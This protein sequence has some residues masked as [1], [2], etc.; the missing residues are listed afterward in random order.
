MSPANPAIEQL[1]IRA[2]A[3][4]W[5]ARAIEAYNDGQPYRFKYDERDRHHRCGYCGSCSAV[6]ALAALRAVG[7]HFSG[8]DWK[9]GWPHKFYLDVPFGPRDSFRMKFYSEHLLDLAEDIEISR[10]SDLWGQAFGVRFERRAGKLH[11]SAVHRGFQTW[12]EVMD[13]GG[14]AERAFAH[15]PA[16]PA[17]PPRWW[18]REAS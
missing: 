18:E 16:A 17:V 9:Y 14:I 5:A 1:V 15:P 6:E 8:C 4:D 10:I 7:T 13:D 11:Y 12:G 3:G 2:H